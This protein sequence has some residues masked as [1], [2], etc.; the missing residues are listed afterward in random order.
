L[1][2]E[3]SK[4]IEDGDR[5][6]TLGPGYPV[7]GGGMRV[8]LRDPNPSPHRALFFRGRG[9]WTLV[10]GRAGSA[11]TSGTISSTLGELAILTDDSPPTISRFSLEGSHSR[12]PHLRFRYHDD[13]SGIEYDSLKTYLDGAVVIA[14][15]DGEHRRAT[16]IPS[17]PLAR[18]T[19]RLTIRIADNMGNQSTVERT[20]TLR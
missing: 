8:T 11:P 7:L 12:L 3:W 5:I 14:D 18:G 17:T 6:Y 20:F 10:G 2:L 13:L 4:R 19:H 9:G 1:L 16:V 15:V